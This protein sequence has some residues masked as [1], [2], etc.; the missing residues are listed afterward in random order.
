MAAEIKTTGSG[1]AQ[2]Q[3]LDAVVVGAGFA[4]LYMLHL[5]RD[6]LGLRVETFEAGDG[7]GGT[8]YWNR[9]PGARCDIPSHH[10]S[11]SFSEEL[12]QEWTWSEKYAAQPEILKYLNFVAEKFD[13][14]R[15]IRFNTRVTSAHYDEGTNR[16]TVKTD[17]GRSL[18]ARFFIPAVGNLSDAAIPEFKG[19]GSF[20]GDVYMTARWPEE[21]VDFK[22]KRVGIIGTGATAMQVIP[23]IAAEADHL[24]VF[25]RTPNYGAPLKNEP[26][27][28]EVDRQAKAN[29]P[30]LR[31]Q[32]WESLAG[33]PF[34]QLRP[35]ALED[36]PEQRRAHYEDCW[37]AG[38]FNV[39]L[40]SYGDILFDIEAN[41]TAAEFMREKI[42]ERVK[43]PEVAEMLC[44]PESQAYG[45]RR[46]A[47]ET[48]YFETF[49]RD[50]VT[51]VDLRKSPIE[52]IVPQGIRTTD[53]EH[54]FDILVYATGFDA[55]TGSLFRMDI[56]GRGGQTLEQH[57]SNGPLTLFGIST[58]GF[59]N[60]F[61]ITGPQSPSVLFNMPLGIE[62]HSEW[63]ADCIAYMDRNGYCSIEPSEKAEQAWIKKT[64]EVANATLLPQ[65]VVDIGFISR[66]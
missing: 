37:E 4:G 33:V 60:L 59:P 36:T 8:W 42:R 3:E 52:E 55:F 43:D 18:S 41:A 61:L 57:W 14:L 38:G 64:D 30:E 23:L 12:Q 54:A 24:T 40:G 21:G 65:T 66:G 34:E 56:R 32:A 10:Y 11:Y 1:H 28:P 20:R 51:L 17:D 2:A 49:N 35:S 48:G 31:R 15:D 27:D 50:N 47:C 6:K 26:M 25:Q 44:P 62:M 9:Y 39:W 46:Q 16:W 53:G 22:G 5:L 45:T 19:H 58:S 29:Y 13:L 7:V 63:I